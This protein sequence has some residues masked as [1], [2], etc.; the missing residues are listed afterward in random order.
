MSGRWGSERIGGIGVSVIV[1][2]L[3]GSSLMVVSLTRS[4]IGR[5]WNQWQIDEK[6]GGISNS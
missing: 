6:V 2:R 3:V 4:G 5:A 1:A